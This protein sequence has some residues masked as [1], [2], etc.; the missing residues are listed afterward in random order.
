MRVC[1]RVRVAYKLLSRIERQLGDV[2]RSLCFVMAF[3]FWSG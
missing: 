3:F 2:M 1:V